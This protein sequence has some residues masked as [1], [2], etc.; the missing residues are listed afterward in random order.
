MNLFGIHTL[1]L[2]HR[3][4]DCFVIPFQGWLPQHRWGDLVR[5][6]NSRSVGSSWHGSMSVLRASD[7]LFHLMCTKIL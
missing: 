2:P 4:R 1:D 5:Q 6:P 3:A 7:T